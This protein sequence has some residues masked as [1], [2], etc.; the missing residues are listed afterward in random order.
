[1]LKKKKGIAL[2]VVLATTLVVLILAILIITISFSN[3][4]FTHHQASRIQ[5]YYAAQAS[6]NYAFQRLSEND[7]QWTTAGSH[8]F[9]RPASGA[10]IIDESLPNSIRIIT[11]TVGAPDSG[12]I[13]GTRFVNARVD[14]TNL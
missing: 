14:Y 10:E 1:M 9:G 4:R 7:L 13:A 3:A 12:N 8:T 11:V 5:A 2:F 6:L